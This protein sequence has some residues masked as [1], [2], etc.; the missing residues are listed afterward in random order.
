MIFNLTSV[1]DVL[2]QKSANYQQPVCHENTVDSASAEDPDSLSSDPA[3]DP[4]PAFQVNHNPDTDLD[5]IR[6]Q[7]FDDLKLKKKKYS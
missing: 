3:T 1:F 4:D 6:I 5:P 7:V 2:T